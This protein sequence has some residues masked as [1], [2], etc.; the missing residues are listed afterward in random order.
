MDSMKKASLIVSIGMVCLTFVFTLSPIAS[1]AKLGV[2]IIFGF[3][4]G[5]IGDIWILQG[6]LKTQATKKDILNSTHKKIK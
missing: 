4:L 3:V 1:L 6:L 5:Y 2:L